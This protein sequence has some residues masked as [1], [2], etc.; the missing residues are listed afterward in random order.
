MRITIMKFL[1]VWLCAGSCLRLTWADQTT[2]EA[3]FR[4]PPGQT[5]PFIHRLVIRAPG[6]VVL[7][8]AATP[9]G[10]E[11]TLL[12]RRPDGTVASQIA[13]SGGNLSLTYFVTRKE[14]ENSGAARSP[15]WSVEVSRAA[16][17]AEV[18]GR[19]RLSHPGP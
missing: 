4:L 9:P 3:R 6:R 15:R 8:V 16:S 7:D 2:A 1:V 5:R 14:V 17:R 18:S 10:V 12:L 13:A 11:I 19:L